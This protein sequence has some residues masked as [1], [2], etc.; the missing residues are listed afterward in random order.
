MIKYVL[1][2]CC[3]ILVG[4]DN[5][6]KTYYHQ[7]NK[8]EYELVMMPVLINDI[9]HQQPIP[10]WKSCPNWKHETNPIYIER[11]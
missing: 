9:I 5:K 6:Q 2:L 1:I 3:F 11:E 10:E 7:C 8:C 4:C